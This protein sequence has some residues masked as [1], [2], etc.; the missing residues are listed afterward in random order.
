MGTVGIYGP[1]IEEDIDMLKR[2]KSNRV[3]HRILTNGIALPVIKNNNSGTTH[4]AKSCD[5]TRGGA[6]FKTRCGYTGFN[7]DDDET[8][9]HIIYYG[10]DG[11]KD[12][13]EITCQKCINIVHNIVISMWYHGYCDDMMTKKSSANEGQI[14]HLI[15]TINVKGIPLYL[16]TT[17]EDGTW[18]ERLTICRL[19]NNKYIPWS[20]FKDLSYYDAKWLQEVVNHIPYTPP[21]RTS[22]RDK[23]EAQRAAMNNHMSEYMRL[24]HEEYL[25]AR[26]FVDE[27]EQN[28]NV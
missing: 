5:N 8:S 17:N 15:N 19:N 14:N 26:R 27:Y 1:H 22:H 6:V 11:I 3:I 12:I 4:L 24:K 13:P 7:H 18:N 25:K 9:K 2:F 28:I 23:T 21:V 16:N 20:N 10:K